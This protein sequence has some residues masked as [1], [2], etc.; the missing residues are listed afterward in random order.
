MSGKCHVCGQ[1]TDLACSDC[2]IDFGV[3]IHVCSK[4][5]CRAYHEEKCSARLRERLKR[6]QE[7]VSP[8]KANVTAEYYEKVAA[9]MRS[10]ELPVR[11]LN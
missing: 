7:T 10:R 2:R 11:A 3:T 5:A 4:P 1:A 8:G 9:K 6:L